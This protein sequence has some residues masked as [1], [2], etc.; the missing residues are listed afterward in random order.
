MQDT[1]LK[2]TKEQPAGVLFVLIISAAL[3]EEHK[4]GSAAAGPPRDARR[5][6]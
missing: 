4:R 5:R 1:T 2:R 6:A 3:V